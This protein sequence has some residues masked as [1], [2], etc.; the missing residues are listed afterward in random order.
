[1]NASPTLPSASEVGQRDLREVVDADRRA[2]GSTTAAHRHQA[3]DRNP[4]SGKPRNTLARFST[5]SERGPL[6]LD[7][8]RTRR[9]TPRTASS[10]RRT[11]RSRNRSRWACPRRSAR[12]GATRWCHSC[13][14]LGCSCTTA[15][16]T[17]IMRQAHEAEH[18]LHR[19]ELHPPDHHPDREAD[20]RDPEQVVDVDHELDRERHAGDLGDQRQHGDEERRA[21]VR[22][23]PCARRAVRARGRTWRAW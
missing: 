21:E 23:T 6:L 10:P 2:V 9:R 3:S 11:A 15:T 22:R 16:T 19:R 7:R 5:R 20:Q 1:M 8:A 14:Q 17:T 18:G 13:D 12:S 4:P